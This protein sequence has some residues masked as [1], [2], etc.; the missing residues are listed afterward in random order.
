MTITETTQK[1]DGQAKSA[2]FVTLVLAGQLCGVSVAE[3]RDILREQ[4]IARVPLAPPDIA[5]SLNLRG[6][7]VTAIDVRRRLQLPPLAAGVRSMA[8]VTEQA[9]ELYALLVDQVCEV[10]WPDPRMFESALATLPP[11]WSRY[12]AG[13]YRLED[14]LMIVLDLNR[15]I[16]LSADMA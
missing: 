10:I 9:G 7:I 13:L 1:A 16:S 14:A 2:G 5:G 12:S 3:V 6:R 11:I 4:P 15:L 8:V